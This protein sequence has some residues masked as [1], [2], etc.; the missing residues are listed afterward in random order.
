MK[1]AVNIINPVLIYSSIWLVV[2]FATSLGITD[3]LLPLNTATIWLVLSNIFSFLLVYMVF[4]VC[5]PNCKSYVHE[6]SISKLSLIRMRK[7]VSGLLLIWVLLSIVEI[8]YCGGVPLAWVFLKIP[9]TYIDFGIPTLHGFINA[10][11]L[12][13]LT[14]LFL[15]WYLHGNRKKLLFILILLLWPI[16]VICRSLLVTVLFQMA[17]IYF[18]FNILNFKKMLLTIL[19]LLGLIVLFGIIGDIRGVA[20]PFSS[21]VIEEYQSTFS[22]LPSG[23][24]WTYVYIT[25]PLS[26]VIANI[27]DINPSYFPYYSILELIP[28]AIRGIIFPNI[29]H[30][31]KLVVENL[32]VSTFYIGFLEDFGIL[33]TILIVTVMQFF[34]VYCYFSALCKKVWAIIAY[35]VLFQCLVFSIFCNLFFL[36]V[37]FAQIILAMCLGKKWTMKTNRRSLLVRS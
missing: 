24:L 2:L 16:A 10:I 4:A 19:L 18:L 37:Y 32:N 21:M 35:A 17:G 25:S 26:N 8:I 23:F 9:K 5:Y 3:N 34:I 33:G 22:N 12:F 20:N 15:D 28:T 14:F 30:S 13:S 29:V 27:N 1:L 7:F 11:Y 36:P 31:T 6:F